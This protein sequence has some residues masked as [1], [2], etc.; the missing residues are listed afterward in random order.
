MSIDQKDPNTQAYHAKYEIYQQWRNAVYEA[1]IDEDMDDD[2]TRWLDCETIHR[3]KWSPNGLPDTLPPKTNYAMVCTQSPKYHAKIIQKHTCGLRYCP[4]CAEM[5][6]ARLLARYVPFISQIATNSYRFRLRHVILTTPYS[7]YDDDIKSRYKQHQKNILAL[8]D[9]LLGKTWRKKQGFLVGDE[10]GE[11]GD[12]L[13]SHILHFGQYI[14]KD[15]ITQAWLKVTGGECRINYVRGIDPDEKSVGDAIKEVLKYCTKFWRA[16]A[17]GSKKMIDP[18]L[19]PALAKVLKGQRRIRTY[20]L[21][22][23]IPKPD[24]EEK[25][26]ECPACGQPMRKIWK[27]DWFVFATTGMI[28]KE[29][30]AIRSKKTLDLI[31][32]NKSLSEIARIRE[33]PPPKQNKLPI[34]DAIPYQVD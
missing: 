3:S 34:F 33:K 14:E 21:F 32:A 30:D 7:L 29:I 8:F 12:L 1:L 31:T 25:V 9:E 17:D 19:I 13:H 5:H 18:Y 26:I 11:D 10:F 24:L 23:G 28:W 20:G 4:T 16:E 22:Y 27:S 6:S 2:A 15:K